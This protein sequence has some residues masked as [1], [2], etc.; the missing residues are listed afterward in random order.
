MSK[1]E[2]D[3]VGILNLKA[4][5][6]IEVRSREEIL[7]TLDK[8]GRFE[9]LPFM[10]EML[11]YCGKKLRVYKRSDKTCDYV[12]GWSIRRM[13][14]TVFL[15]GVRCD[16]GSH[17]GCEASCLIWWNEHWLKRADPQ[18]LSADALRKTAPGST[19]DGFFS[20][21]QLL[22]GAQSVNA[23]GDTIYSCQ[24]MHVKEFTTYMA[25]WDPRQYVRDIRSGNIATGLGGSSRGQQ[26][27]E[28]VLAVL[29]VI[30]AVIISFYNHTQEKRSRK[31]FPFI[32]GS[33]VNPTVEVLNLQP[34]EFVQVR[35]KE[36][37][38]QTLAKNQKNR[39]LWFDAEQLPYCGGIY[40]VLRRVNKIIDENNGKMLDMKNP[41]IILDGVICKSEFHRLCPRAVYPYWRENWLMRVT[42]APACAPLE[43]LAERCDR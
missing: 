41:C 9:N 11:Q 32:E 4:G 23:E 28:T 34:G 43:Q 29:Q 14:D 40:R 24:A 6:W 42:E 18:L 7:A 1:I 8:H 15:E 35:S 30:R 13:T 26:F 16:G 25:P 22:V 5:D 27:M 33:T 10:P 19:S 12:A 37:I 38:M 2:K 21:E 31:I 20:V 17:G 3:R 39:G 36:E